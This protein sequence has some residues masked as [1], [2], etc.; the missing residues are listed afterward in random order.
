[1]NI[2]LPKGIFKRGNSYALRY[3]V[4]T[5]IQSVVGKKEIIR[6]LGT[7]DL[8]EALSN[9]EST[10]K[11]IKASL[12]EKNKTKQRSTQRKRKDE[13]TVRFTAHKWLLES[14]GIAASTRNRY[15]GILES[16]EVY[17]G[18]TEVTKINRKMALG[19]IEHLK[20]TPSAKTGQLL[21]HRSLSAYQ[22][23]LASYWSVLDYWGL[24]DG[25]MRNPFSGLLRRIAG[26]RKKVDTRKKKLRPV[27]REEAEC[28]LEYISETPIL[29]YQREMFVVV[30]LLWVSACRL[31]EIASLS[32]KDIDDQGDHFVLNIT[33]AKTGPVPL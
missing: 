9:R 25:D 21:S 2:T 7:S 5:E 28:L 31:N 15:R 13:T 33:N 22:I 16:F 26:Q 1:M 14:D 18:N 11:E 23:C 10:L 24:V 4:P 17:S 32:L 20:V 27:T 8:G 19:F 29:K 6:S 30:R 12:F 3:S